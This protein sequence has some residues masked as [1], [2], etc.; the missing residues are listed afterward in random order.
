MD[1]SG[2]DLDA[3]FAM[4]QGQ[5][6]DDIVSS[7]D[8]AN[9]RRSMPV[10]GGN[11][12]AVNSPDGRRFSSM[13][14]GG[15]GNSA[16]DDFQFDM[17]ATGMD[18]MLPTATFPRTTAELQNDRL[19]ATDLAINTQ[20]S[21]ANANSPFSNVA[22]VVN[23]A[24]VANGG[25][26]YASPM[27]H[28]GS[29][30]MDMTPYPNDLPMPL[31]MT[32]PMSLLPNDINMFPNSAFSPAM[33]D[34]PV[35][36]DFGT[37]QTSGPQDNSMAMQSRENVRSESSSVTPRLHPNMPTRTNSQ[38]QK[39]M[40]SDSRSR[41]D[42]RS[43]PAPITK[44]HRDEQTIAAKPRTNPAASGAPNSATEVRGGFICQEQFPMVHALRWI[45]VN[46]RQEPPHEDAIQECL[47]VYRL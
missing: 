21:Q 47:L 5:S 33:M 29:L 17:S 24:N 34:S 15:P 19:P 31:D 16:M 10:Y 4:G 14:F 43:N 12:M 37:P 39:G 46:Q 7:N 40:L 26:A 6:L 22:N 27:Q 23:V 1:M 35:A 11:Q 30:D 9:R 42:S 25:S 45:P 3:A 36:Q 18:A 13:N 44:W 32:D 20:F 38:D 8:K 28:N 41:S 2:D